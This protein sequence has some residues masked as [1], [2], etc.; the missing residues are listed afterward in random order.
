MKKPAR[1]TDHPEKGRSQPHEVR[2]PGFIVEENIGLGDVVK[3]VSYAIGVRPCAGCEKRG[4][5]L[6][7]WL[8]FSGR[9]GGQS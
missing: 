7:R 2:L 8:T 6:N 4:A 9:G 1:N 3:R 5:L